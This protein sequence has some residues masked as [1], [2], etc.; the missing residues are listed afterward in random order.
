MNWLFVD[1]F[2]SECDVFLLTQPSS[3]PEE[4]ALP[5]SSKDKDSSAIKKKA[6]KGKAAA[7]GRQVDFNPPSWGSN[8][9][10]PRRATPAPSVPAAVAR[11]QP[12]SEG[13]VG[14][15]DVDL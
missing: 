4:P 14:W 12:F 2:F 15:T 5:S 10:R 9:A 3:P 6:S 13:P 1:A 8:R 7:G 11:G